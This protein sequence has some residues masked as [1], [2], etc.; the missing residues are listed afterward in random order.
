MHWSCI[1]RWKQQL[2]QGA[3]LLMSALCIV[4]PCCR[5]RPA[6]FSSLVFHRH[7]GAGAHS[8]FFSFSIETPEKPASSLKAERTF[9]SNFSGLAILH[10]WFCIFFSRR[11]GGLVAAAAAAGSV[12]PTTQVV[13]LVFLIE[14]LEMKATGTAKKR[15]GSLGNNTHHPSAK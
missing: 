15:E 1:A 13:S 10:L 14:E 4:W 9:Y 3:R 8:R 12:E 7:A 6:G 2:Y 11:F 5:H